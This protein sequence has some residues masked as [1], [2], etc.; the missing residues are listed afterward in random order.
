MANF[1]FNKVIIGGRLTSDPELKTTPSGISV[2]SFTVAVNRRGKSDET[3]FHNCTA[4]RNAAEFIT[5][6]FRKGSSICIVGSLQNRNWTDNDGNKHY[7]TDI[8]VDETY[9]VDSKGESSAPSNTAPAPIT[10]IPTAYTEV[11][12]F[13][14]IDDPDCPF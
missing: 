11:P 5:K 7:A 13:D 1:N 9:F 12:Q 14:E 8:V 2:T 6:Y 3:D 10:Y 4:W